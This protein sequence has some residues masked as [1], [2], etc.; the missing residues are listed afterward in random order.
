LW[1]L[2]GMRPLAG[3]TRSLTKLTHRGVGFIQGEVKA[4]DP[5][6]RLVQVGSEE[7]EADAILIALGAPHSLAHLALL[8]SSAHAHNLYDAEALPAMHTD[9][10]AIDGGSLLVSIMGSPFQCPPAPFEAILLIDEALRERGV[11]DQISMA[12]STPQPMTVPVAGVD[13][14]RYVADHLG[15]R[16]IELLPE[17]QLTF[18]EGRTAS[19][20]NGA[21]RSFSV[22]LGVPASVPPPLVATAGLAGGSG[23]IEPET[24]TLRTSFERVYAV[25]DCTHIPN[26]IGALPK[27][28]VFA[29]GEAV[30][31]ARNIAA[32]LV[33]SE[34]ATFDGYGY[35][36]LELP[37][38]RVAFIEGNFLAEPRPDVTLSEPD[39]EQFLRKQAFERDHLDAWLG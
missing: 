18:V 15:E 36:F 6:T 13:A 3:G 27:A 14:S 21:T 25:G 1:D 30:V 17:H 33:G 35:C 16:D 12:I 28:G 37:G 22:L 34:P 24:A 4:L 29:A 31:A 23:F 2:S 10:D 32:D 19:F 26:A 9:L 8:W 5:S 20:A 39:H 7:I 11:R 38:E